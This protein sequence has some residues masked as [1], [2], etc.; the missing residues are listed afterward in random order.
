MKLIAL[1]SV[2]LL[3]SCVPPKATPVPEA[4]ATESWDYPAWN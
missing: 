1:L 4:K 2:I 3:S